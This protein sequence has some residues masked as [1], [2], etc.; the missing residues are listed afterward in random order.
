M[1]G[2]LEYGMSFFGVAQL[3]WLSL[4]VTVAQ[5]EKGE[6]DQ[7]KQCQERVW[8]SASYS[9]VSSSCQSGNEVHVGLPIVC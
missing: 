8:S 1:C 7:Q 2:F 3:G 9:T 4:T 6:S 5:L